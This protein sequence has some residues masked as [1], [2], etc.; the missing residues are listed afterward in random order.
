MNMGLGIVADERDGLVPAAAEPSVRPTAI[1]RYLRV[2]VDV[3][4]DGVPTR[5]NIRVPL[6]LLR[7][8]VRLAALIPP[9]ALDAAN[10]S[11][12]RSGLPI[13]LAQLRPEQL[14]ALVEH[15]DEMTVEVDQPDAKVRVFCE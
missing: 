4:D 6:Q 12:A 13:D 7:T 1:P 8:G 10:A 2:L 15:V 11:L 5:V 9:R 14:E 3:T